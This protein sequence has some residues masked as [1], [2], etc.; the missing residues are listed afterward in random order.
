MKDFEIFELGD[1]QLQ[2]KRTIRSAKLAY[3]T[4]GT[5]NAAKD[6]VILYP[7]SFAASHDDTAWLVGPGRALAAITAD[8]IIMPCSSDLYFPPEDAAYEAERIARAELRIL[9][10]PWGHV[11]GEGLNDADTAFIEQAIR[12]LLAR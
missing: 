9:N 2:S 7:T 5:L 8:T 10:S 4:F 6:N 12:D 1:I 3:K 11:A